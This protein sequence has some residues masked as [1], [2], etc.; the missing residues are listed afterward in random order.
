MTSLLQNDSW[1]KIWANQLIYD[2]SW[3]YKS[4]WLTF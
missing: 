2:T 4:W 3:R 1:R